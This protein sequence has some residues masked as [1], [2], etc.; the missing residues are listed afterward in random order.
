MAPISPGFTVGAIFVFEYPCPTIL[1]NARV[2][3]RKG[4]VGPNLGQQVH[5]LKQR[6]GVELLHGADERVPQVRI[7]E[8]FA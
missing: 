4:R 5:Q 7:G 2:S 6:P 3:S 1:L 8:S